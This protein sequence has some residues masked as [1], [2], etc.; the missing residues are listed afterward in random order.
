[1]G[2]SGGG[3]ARSLFQAL[4]EPGLPFAAGSRSARR[5]AMGDGR[6]RVSTGVADIRVCGV[7]VL[8]PGEIQVAVYQGLD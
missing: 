2:A 4:R 6:S 8:S 7:F 3:G 5:R 1:M